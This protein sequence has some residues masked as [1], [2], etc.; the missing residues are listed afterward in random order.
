MNMFPI[1][2]L[3]ASMMIAPTKV[4][5]EELSRKCVLAI[6]SGKELYSASVHSVKVFL[7]EDNI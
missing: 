6:D 7:C 5:M 2:T 3:Q 4:R 1:V